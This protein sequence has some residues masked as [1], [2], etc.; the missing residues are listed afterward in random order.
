MVGVSPDLFR[1]PPDIGVVMLRIGELAAAGEDHLRGLGGELAAGVGGAGLDDDRPALDRP[2]DVQGAAHRQEL[3]LVVEHVHPL[4]VEIN[5]VLDIADEG[6]IGPAVPEAGDDVEELAGAAVALAVLHLL[7]QPEIERRVGVR[8]GDQVPAGAPAADMVEGGETPR[9]R[10]GRLEGGGGGGDQPDMLG[11]HRQYR[12]QGQRI[13]RGDRRA[14]LQRR[15]RHV[16]HA[17][18]VRHEPGV[19][20]AAL[21]GLGKADQVLEI[22]IGVGIGAGVAPPGGV[23]ADRAHECAQMQLAWSCHRCPVLDPAPSWIGCRRHR[24]IRGIGPK[25]CYRGPSLNP[26]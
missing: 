13:E 24:N 20:A 9:D 25:G 5:P 7:G 12:Q 16:E 8:S 17:E 10:V 6:V 14:A 21:Q 2:G 11:H 22:E 26:G 1:P 3:A 18:M 19:K 4:G 23:D 15:H